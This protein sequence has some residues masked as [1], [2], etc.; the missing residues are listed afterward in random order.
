[1]EFT[2][3]YEGRFPRRTL[4][5][6]EMLEVRDATAVLS[7]MSPAEL[8]EIAGVLGRFKLQ[9]ADILKPGGQEGPVA[10]RLNR[11]FRELGWREGRH[12]L[13]ISSS[14]RLM[15]YR[16]AGE[17]EAVTAESEVVSEGYKVD[18]LKGKVALDVEWNAKDGNL[19]RDLGAYR[20]FYDAGIIGAGVILT[21]TQADLR[22]LGER[23]GRDPFSTSTTTN[24][25]K[26]QP[27]LARGDGGG[28]PVLAIA[29]T[30]KCFEEAG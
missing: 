12:D 13:T 24:L 15:P 6:Y 30:A 17:R 1:M 3:S 18:N 10:K 21:R 26:L 16:A 5:R 11:A 20:T 4:D 14:L 27:R 19:D 23:L 8:E 22:S 7:S 2:Q 29:I 28:C 25:D 9:R